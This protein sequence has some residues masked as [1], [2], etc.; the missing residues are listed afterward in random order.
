MRRFFSCLVSVS[1]IIALALISF[2]G[3]QAWIETH[4]GQSLVTHATVGIDHYKLPTFSGSLDDSGYDVSF[5]QCQSV[6]S[7]KSVGFVIIGLNH[8]KPL[9]AN[10]CFNDQ[11]R[12]ARQHAAAAVYINVSDPGQL[13]ATSRGNQI[14]DDTIS[15]LT[16]AGVAND[17]PVWLDVETHNSWSDT[18]RAVT[19]LNT[20]IKELHSHG[21]PVGIYST[22][23][24]WFTIT[25]DANVT[26]P[27]W[28]AIGKYSS[29]S[30]GVA[31]A[32]NTCSSSS[33]GGRSPGIVQF[34]AK[35][36]GV[37][38]D[39]NIMCTSPAGLVARPQ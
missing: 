10:P 29:I 25:M 17:V 14:A 16:N 28:V 3:V 37:W 11:W 30:A 22:P 26:V 8:G 7:N 27:T 5:P 32:K 35:S 39:R 1:A 9:T 36:D 6:L 24:E 12:W 13:T 34:V 38:R 15:K 19:M 2:L 31:G 20:V 4:H 21:H 33:F 23:V 18:D